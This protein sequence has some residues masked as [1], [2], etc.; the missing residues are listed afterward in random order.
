VYVECSK[1]NADTQRIT[2]HHLRP[3]GVASPLVVVLARP[4][5]R[6]LYC[7][8]FL[9][10]CPFHPRRYVSIRYLEVQAEALASFQQGVSLEVPV[11]L[12]YHVRHHL[13]H[14]C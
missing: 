1:Q 5:S 2:T 10:V 3:S 11:G 9:A 8:H 4:L 6:L 13:E 14:R 12:A 7:H